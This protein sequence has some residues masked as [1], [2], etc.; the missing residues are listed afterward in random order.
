METKVSKHLRIPTWRFEWFEAEAKRQGRSVNAE[1]NMALVYWKETREKEPMI[2]EEKD[3]NITADDIKWDRHLIREY[4]AKIRDYEAKADA[5][6]GP[7]RGAYRGL[8]TKTK[9]G[10]DAMSGNLA[11]HLDWLRRFKPDV[12]EQMK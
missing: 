5:S 1:M 8:V 4:E 6:K 9:K 10:L 2:P 11:Y 7:R 3:F 12:Y